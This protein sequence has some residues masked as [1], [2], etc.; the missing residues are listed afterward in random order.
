M[1]QPLPPYHVEVLKDNQWMKLAE[2]GLREPFRISVG[3]ADSDY[4]VRMN[5]QDP[6]TIPGRLMRK[7]NFGGFYTDTIAYP[8]AGSFELDLKAVQVR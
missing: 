7:I 2:V 5:D 6:I 4:T 8:S 1:S 3:M